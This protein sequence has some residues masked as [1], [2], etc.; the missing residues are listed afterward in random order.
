M[1]LQNIANPFSLTK[2]STLK[3]LPSLKPGQMISAKVLELFPNQKATIQVNGK[4]IVAQLETALTAKK[5]YLF[6]V[7]SAGDVTRIKKNNRNTSKKMTVV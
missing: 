3:Q 2:P 6:Q 4:E 1:S 7:I 5:S